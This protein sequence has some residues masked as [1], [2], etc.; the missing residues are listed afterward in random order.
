LSPKDRETLESIFIFREK[1]LN[2]IKELEDE[3]AET[4]YEIEQIDITE[5]DNK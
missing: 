2:E 1:L 4:Q 5:G 3:L